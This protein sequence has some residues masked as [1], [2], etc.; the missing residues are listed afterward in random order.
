[1]GVIRSGLKSCVCADV[2]FL[3]CDA[4]GVALRLEAVLMRP[5]RVEV[6]TGNRG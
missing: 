1:M 2:A 6:V 4:M 5:E 3:P